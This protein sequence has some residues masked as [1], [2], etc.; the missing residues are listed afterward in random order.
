ML[1]LSSFRLKMPT[2]SLSM[3]T[4]GKCLR[5]PATGRDVSTVGAV[6]CGCGRPRRRT[7]QGGGRSVSA[8]RRRRRRRSARRRRAG[9]RA[10]GG[11]GGVRAGVVLAPDAHRAADPKDADER[12]LLADRK[13]PDATAAPTPE[14]NRANFV[15]EGAS[16]IDAIRGDSGGFCAWGR[17][18][19]SLIRGSSSRPVFVVVLFCV[20]ARAWAG[21][22]ERGGCGGAVDDLLGRSGKVDQRTG[23]S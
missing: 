2:T 15:A 4:T 13:R 21:A 5:P 19:E 18:M 20:C 7:S 6:S 17:H 14:V 9:G 10:V 16:A 1:H 8:S 22:G 11:S 23:G 3:L 12:S